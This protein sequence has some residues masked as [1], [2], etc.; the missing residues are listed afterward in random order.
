MKEY[1]KAI[2][3]LTTMTLSCILAVFVGNWL[4]EQLHTT[5][6]VF[7]GLLFYAIGANFYLLWKG[8]SIDE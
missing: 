6:W 3:F 4:D 7:L 5:P 2:R 1:S 8:L